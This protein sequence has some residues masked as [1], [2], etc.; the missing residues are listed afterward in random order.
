MAICL[1]G[2]FDYDETIR[3]IEK[4]WG[5]FEIKDQPT[6]EVREESPITEVVEKEVWGPEAERLYMG[7]RFNGANTEDSR[8][9][10]MTD[11]VLSNSSAGLIDLN[12]I[13]RHHNQI[14]YS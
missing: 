11:M 12:L 13:L 1:S 4:Y 9:L 10:T 8:M 7:F 5:E 14:I 2:D 6:F 3:L